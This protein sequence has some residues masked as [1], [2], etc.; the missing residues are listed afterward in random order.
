[1]RIKSEDAASEL[2]CRRPV[3]RA[4][5]SPEM[6]KNEN[7]DMDGVF[8]IMVLGGSSDISDICSELQ[9]FESILPCFSR[10]APSS[11]HP[12]SSGHNFNNCN[13]EKMS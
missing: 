1:M 10:N 9:P 6:G 4:T 5:A 11:P 8:L 7:E 12:S 2:G 13:L 3:R